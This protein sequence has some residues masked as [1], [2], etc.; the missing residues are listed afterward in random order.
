MSHRVF[1]SKMTMA[2]ALGVVSLTAA[3]MAQGQE[4]SKVKVEEV[5]GGIAAAIR[6]SAGSH[7]K[8]LPDKLID[9]SRTPDARG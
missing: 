5:A 2:V 6:G 3:P 4:Q 9:P 8:K 7:L 1:G